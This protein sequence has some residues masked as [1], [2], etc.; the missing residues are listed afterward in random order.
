MAS[1]NELAE[2]VPLCTLSVATLCIGLQVCT[3]I[4]GGFLREVRHDARY[5]RRN[6]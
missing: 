1:L 2:Q 3:G 5:A 4:R 6:P